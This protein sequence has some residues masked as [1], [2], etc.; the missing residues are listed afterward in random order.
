MALKL[1]R[2]KSGSET[3]IPGVASKGAVASQS[4]GSAKRASVTA[5]KRVETS[6][7]RTCL[8]WFI[9]GRLAFAAC[10]ALGGHCVLGGHCAIG[11]QGS[12]PMAGGSQRDVRSGGRGG[13]AV[14]AAFAVQP[15]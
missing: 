11:G 7:P 4:M 5:R 3:P 10:L 9:A 2:V 8:T 12:G 6:L 15:Q 1:A 14:A 13:G